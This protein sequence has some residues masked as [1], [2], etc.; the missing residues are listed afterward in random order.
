M[1][2]NVWKKIIV[3][4]SLGFAATGAGA[5]TLEYGRTCEKAVGRD[6]TNKSFKILALGI[7]ETSDRGLQIWVDSQSNNAITLSKKELRGLDMVA[8]AEALANDKADVVILCWS[9]AV[10]LMIDGVDAVALKFKIRK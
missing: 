8:T 3:T 1:N 5:S 7:N 2:F 10:S 4:L 9:D 6:F